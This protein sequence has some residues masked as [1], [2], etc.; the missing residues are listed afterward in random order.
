MRRLPTISL[1]PL[2]IALGA[3]SAQ[4]SPRS[5]PHLVA[6]IATWDE[7]IPLGNGLL[8]GLLWGGDS[9]LNIS[10]DRG[11]LWDLRP[12]ARYGSDGYR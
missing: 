11:D 1:H 7:A 12:A 5:N 6:P 10:L 4:P 3:L 9:R 2:T 8:G